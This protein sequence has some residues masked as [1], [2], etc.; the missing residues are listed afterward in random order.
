MFHHGPAM[1]EGCFTVVGGA[2]GFVSWKEHFLKLYQQAKTQEIR[3]WVQPRELPAYLTH[4][5]R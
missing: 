1:T 4:L 5:S 3:V 2:K